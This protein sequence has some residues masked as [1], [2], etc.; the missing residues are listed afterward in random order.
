M[1]PL[2]GETEN[3]STSCGSPRLGAIQSE[4]SSAPTSSPYP[5]V[6]NHRSH[7]ITGYLSTI[8]IRTVKQDRN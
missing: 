3:S 2:E 8:H 6:S 7:V 4:S 1:V 5:I